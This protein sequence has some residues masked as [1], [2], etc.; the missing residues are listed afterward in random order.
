MDGEERMM[1][2]RQALVKD[3][4]TAPYQLPEIFFQ[5][6]F[7]SPLMMPILIGDSSFGIIWP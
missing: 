2:I 5:E 6:A 7:D 3:V 4:M 1:I